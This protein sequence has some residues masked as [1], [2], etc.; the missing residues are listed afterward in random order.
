MP[1]SHI[2][3]HDTYTVVSRR[4]AAW[5]SGDTLVSINLVAPHRARLL[6]TWMGD[7][8]L[9]GKLSRYVP[10]HLG[11]LSLPS[12]RGRLNESVWL[13]LGRVRSLVSG[14]R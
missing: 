14:G 2:H 5:C 12:L 4:L 7:R 11:Q 13:G 6:A 9:T 3:E 10:N 8:L 1:N